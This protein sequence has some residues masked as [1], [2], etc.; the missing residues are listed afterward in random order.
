MNPNTKVSKEIWDIMNKRWNLM[1][2]KSLELQTMIRFNELKQSIPGISANVLSD[3]LDELEKIGLVKR[4]VSNDTSVHIGY[5]LN[6]KC[7]NLKKIL[8]DLDEW[9][10]LYK[11]DNEIQVTTNNFIITKQLV[12]L[13][14]NEISETEFNFI[15]DKLLF[16]FGNDSFDLVKNFNILKN[17]IYELYGVELG[18]KIVEKLIKHMESFKKNI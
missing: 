5:L 8:T 3:K 18:N 11:S 16:S 4:I 6:E 9:V 1:I 12:E 13:L 10:S 15:Q 2:L 14:K 17:I 7:E